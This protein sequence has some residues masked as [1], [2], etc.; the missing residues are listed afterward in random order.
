[1]PLNSGNVG[2]GLAAKPASNIPDTRDYELFNPPFGE[3]AYGRVWLVRNAIG[4]WQ[5]LKAVY[6]AKFGHNSGP[7]ETEFKGIKRYKP[8]SE[9][10][11][12]LLRVDFV[13]KKRDGYFYYVMELVTRSPLAGRKIRLRTSLAIWPG[14]APRRRAAA[15]RARVGTDHGRPSRGV[16]L[17]PPPEPHASRH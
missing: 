9:K 11:P 7:Y 5:A 16:G 2:T 3:G 4:Q 15:A 10:H 6:Q 13:S 17:S 14:Y 12:G 8:V 1:M